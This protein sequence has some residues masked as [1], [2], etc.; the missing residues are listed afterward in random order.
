MG[1]NVVCAMATGP[2]KEKPLTLSGGL[3]SESTGCEGRLLMV[4][5]FR[6]TAV[7]KKEKP[8]TVERPVTRKLNHLRGETA[9]LEQSWRRGG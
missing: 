6:G 7:L 2:Q 1:K 5:S 3:D 4:S 9:Q 8:L